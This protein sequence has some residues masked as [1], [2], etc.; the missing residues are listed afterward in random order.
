MYAKL[1]AQ[2]TNP[3]GCTLGSSPAPASGEP[4]A[5]A[6]NVSEVHTTNPKKCFP[7]KII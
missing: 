4:S 1:R 5:A 7:G 3:T 2:L 6:T